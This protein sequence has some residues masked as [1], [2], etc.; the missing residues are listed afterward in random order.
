[1]FRLSLV[2]NLWHL[3]NLHKFRKFTFC[4]VAIFPSRSSRSSF[5]CCC[6]SSTRY[7]LLWTISNTT[8]C[9]LDSQYPLTP[10]FSLQLAFEADRPRLC[11]APKYELHA[12]AWHVARALVLAL[13]PPMLPVLSAATVNVKVIIPSSPSVSASFPHPQA[14]CPDQD[15]IESFPHAW[16]PRLSL[17]SAVWRC[18]CTFVESQ[19]FESCPPPP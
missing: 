14:L 1:M 9:W 13:S 12:L 3:G 19:L 6:N 7:S 4:F 18:E 10:V 15:V 5:I 16:A 17:Q 2:Q 8:L 11:R